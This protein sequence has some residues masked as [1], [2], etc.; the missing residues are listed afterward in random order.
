MKA[1]DK[2]ENEWPVPQIDPNL[3]DGCNLC[4]QVCPNHVLVLRYNLAV[5]AHPELCDYS[6]LCEQACPQKAIQRLFEILILNDEE[7]E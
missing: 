5:V 2:T 7:T 4:V 3:C 1:V 6:G